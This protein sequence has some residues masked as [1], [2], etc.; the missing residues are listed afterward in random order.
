MKFPIRDDYSSESGGWT[1]QQPSTRTTDKHGKC[2][3][4]TRTGVRLDFHHW[5]YQNDIGCEI[6][7]EC[8]EHA[9]G[10]HGTKPSH[11]VGNSWVPACFRRL[12]ERY[13]ENHHYVSERRVF[14]QLS[15]PRKHR[16]ELSEY[17][18]VGR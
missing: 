11:T 16:E 6:C 18:G 9:H 3:V 2:P 8:H 7:R 4:C 1:P 17:V 10:E 15:I 14:R 13:R 12:M 5:D